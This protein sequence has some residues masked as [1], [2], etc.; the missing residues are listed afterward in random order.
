M[1]GL[2]WPYLALPLR[3]NPI[4][5]FSASAG[6]L[7]TLETR[8]G[9]DP[10]RNRLAGIPDAGES[11]RRKK[12]S[13]VVS[14]RRE[15]GFGRTEKERRQGSVIFSEMGRVCGRE[16]SPLAARRGLRPRGPVGSGTG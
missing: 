4:G 9:P 3:W 14:A 12:T 7:R 6:R 2:T 10:G 1:S 5:A 8:C 15:I 11:Q 13:S 16:H